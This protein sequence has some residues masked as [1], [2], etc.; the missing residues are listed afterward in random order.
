M[1]RLRSGYSTTTYSVML[2]GAPADCTGVH[3]RLL[4]FVHVLYCIYKDYCNGEV[5]QVFPYSG[6]ELKAKEKI[7]K[8]IWK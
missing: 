3:G 6:Y 8:N 4:F 1:I 5:E 7:N 2:N